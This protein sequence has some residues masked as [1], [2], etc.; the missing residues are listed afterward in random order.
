MDLK[1]AQEAGAA[2][3]TEL[4]SIDPLVDENGVAVVPYGVTRARKDSLHSYKLKRLYIPSTLTEVEAYP[5]SYFSVKCEAIV[6]YEGQDGLVVIEDNESSDYDLRYITHYESFPVLSDSQ[7]PKSHGE[8]FKVNANFTAD[9]V[10]GG[11]L[12]L[13]LVGESKL[14]AE[15]DGALYDRN[16]ETLLYFPG[17]GKKRDISKLPQSVTAISQEAFYGA[18]LK[19]GRLKQSPLRIETNAFNRA[20]MPSLALPSGVELGTFFYEEKTRSPFSCSLL[21]E[22]RGAFYGSRIDTIVLPDDIEEIPAGTFCKS[23][24]KDLEIPDSVTKLG[25]DCFKNCGSLSLVVPDTVEQIEEN[26]CSGLKSVSLPAWTAE[27]YR[28]FLKCQKGCTVAIRNNEGSFAYA[29]YVPEDGIAQMYG[30]RLAGGLAFKLTDEYFKKGYF[31]SLDAK[32]HV[33]LTR[34]CFTCDTDN[35]PDQEMVGEYEAYLKKNA[36]KAVKLFEEERDNVCLSMLESLGYSQESLKKQIK[37]DEAKPKAPTVAQLSNEAV[38]A[39]GK[40]DSNKL[41]NLAPI[42]KKVRPAVAVQLLM[43][44]AEAGDLDAVKKLYGMFGEFEMPSLALSRALA[45]GHEEVARYLISQGASLTSK[46]KRIDISGSDAK[47]LKNREERYLTQILTEGMLDIPGRNA[48]RIGTTGYLYFASLSSKSDRVITALVDDG[49]LSAADMTGLLFASLVDTNEYFRPGEPRK[50]LAQKLYEKLG[51]AKVA[52]P[53]TYQDLRLSHWHEIN[54][55]DQLIFPSCDNKTIEAVCS[56]MPERIPAMWDPG[57]VRYPEA[58]K[59]LAKHL[60]PEGF[61]NETAL[62]NVLAKNGFTDE[63]KHLASA[64]FVFSE[65]ARTKAAAMARDGGFEDTARAIESIE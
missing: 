64:G 54:A 49:L 53:M 61:S 23:S 65:S 57:F 60:K 37:S 26:A 33:A 9:E 32:I 47:Q 25:A 43:L 7:L 41:D 16:V 5:F 58:A 46:I 50:K 19:A 36:K 40:G 27:N 2:E 56:V 17:E 3:G 10:R 15:I 12:P 63:I 48:Y 62:L 1:R 24:V 13:E 44:A 51:S 11:S 52:V 59:K 18:N 55:I 8:V 14:Y 39:M 38:A 34:L 42:A 35:A 4:V 30:D 45:F 20:K 22:W 28:D 6:S 31:K 21:K 29:S